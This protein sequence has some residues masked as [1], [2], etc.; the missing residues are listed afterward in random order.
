MDLV[1]WSR[2]G[3]S[4]VG[5]GSP[6]GREGKAVEFGILGPLQVVDD[7]QAIAIGG[8]KLQSLMALLILN[9]NR[10]V[11]TDRLLDELWGD[12]AAGR[13][14]TLWVYI[15]RLRAAL[16]ERDILV[17]RDH[18]Y[19][20][21]IGPDDLDASRFETMVAAGR[22]LMSN[23]PARASQLLSDGLALWRGPAF[24]EFSYEDFA[25]AEIVRLEELRSLAV[26]DRIE[27]DLKL[28]RSGE[29]ISELESLH[30]AYPTR[31]RLVS[32]LMLALYRSGRQID[33]LAVFRR[34]RLHLV[35]EL[36]VDPSPELRRLEEQILL[37]DS[38]LQARHRGSHSNDEPIPDGAPNPFKG[39]R[40]FL[41]DD[42]GD[43]FGRDRIVA[44]AVRR[45]ATDTALLALVGPSGSG[46]SSIV[47]AGLIPA[48]RKGAIEGS[49][50]WL[51]AQMVP[52]SRPF[53]ELEAALLRSSLDAPDSLSDQL[54]DR[55]AGMLRAALRVLPTD[56]S[57]LVLVIDQFEELFTQVTH[58][59]DCGDF[60]TGLLNAIDDSRGRVKVVITLRADFYDRPL[61]YPEFGARLGDGIINVVPLTS[62][63]LE[64]AALQPAER[65]GVML[66]PALIATLLTD[67]I[68]RPGALPL[69]QYALTELFDRR[70]DNTLSLGAYH[71][72]D[73][74]S[75][76]LSRR[77]DDLFAQLDD[78]QQA[79]ARQLFLRLVS[80]A[81]T[82]EWT[83]RRVPA[84]E[85]LSLDVDVFALQTVIDS[86]SAHRLLILDRDVVTDSPTVE[87]AHEA[88]LTNWTRLSD[89]IEAAREDVKRHVSLAAAMAEW[90]DADFNHDFLLRG[91]R[92][93]AYTTWAATATMQLTLD[94]RQF[95]DL[96]TVRHENTLE[97]EQ[98]R[99][100]RGDRAERS[101]RRR[102]WAVAAVVVL[103]IGATGA[104]AA[105]VF[106]SG[107]GPTVAFF[108]DRSDDGWNANIGAGLDRAANDINMNLI[109]APSVIDPGAELPKL[110]E[111]SP[112]VIISDGTLIFASPEVLGDFPDIRF[113]LV[114]GFFDAPN[115]VSVSFANEQGA[116]LAGVAAALKSET[117]VVGFVGATA[118]PN[119]EEFRAGFEAGAV[120][121]DPD[122]E[123]LA[124]FIEQQFMAEVGGLV[125]AFADPQLGYDRAVS[126]YQRNADVVFH[127]SGF[128]GWGLF[129]A[130][131][132]QSESTGRR[133]WAIGV[134]NDQ[135]FD[136]NPVQRD[137]VLTSVIKRGDNAAYQLIKRML[138][139]DVVGEIASVGLAEHAFDYSTQGGG[140]TAEIAATVDRAIDDIINGRI[141]VATTP[142]GEVLNL[143]EA[144][145]AF[146]A[147][148]SGRSSNQIDEQLGAT[149]ERHSEE[150]DASCADQHH[151]RI[152]AEFFIRYADE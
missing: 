22:V 132:D 106:D 87:V 27:A 39:L 73:G 111:S 57:N 9:A 52:G 142:V 104:Y 81:D 123:V 103:V 125:N 118:I 146:E 49:D 29:L 138:G 70:I 14:K 112:D 30:R 130:V 110:A 50:G 42:D 105:G 89:W 136:V 72:M 74:V 119:I 10:V 35:E 40:S 7:G 148:F 51:I 122:V 147:A 58:E 94:E 31:E 3:R 32:Q 24:E 55:E 43:F 38:R 86:Y 2:T 37:H 53:A 28:G 114:D 6:R 85:I 61:A 91:A 67:V 66:E 120:W 64:S 101:A 133:L 108:G 126:L 93:E 18:G 5:L 149:V 34:Y 33:S 109:D 12:D 19:S 127:A 83:R 124:T 137:Y 99:S 25:Q 134:D 141:V 128:S 45:L 92:L 102:L 21:L 65:A 47:R 13:E 78:E 88:L 143:D 11:T 8:R 26:E 144:Q 69:F 41:E 60:L 131:V 77:A 76:A 129:D 63:E 150:F 59:A 68:G 151:G 116:F 4:A 75:G 121:A 48:L 95:L 16:G 98:T 15:S 100:M 140:M 56:T 17:T 117:G 96:S 135:W 1:N 139:D 36:G 84:S 54:A 20:L 152:C 115:A 79:T 107:P 46:K 113:G 71:A 97:E 23:D 44:E 80:I 90:S 145:N 62:N 82:D